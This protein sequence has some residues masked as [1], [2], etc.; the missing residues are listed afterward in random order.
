MGTFVE[1][2]QE[3]WDCS[4]VLSRPSAFQIASILRCRVPRHHF[5][6]VSNQAISSQVG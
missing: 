3:L 6:L 2:L 5:R 1:R 4:E